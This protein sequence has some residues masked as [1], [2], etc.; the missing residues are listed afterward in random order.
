MANT[1]SD[2]SLTISQLC[3]AAG[4]TPRTVHYYVQQG[5]LPPASVQGRHGTYDSRHLDRLRAI[6]KLQSE[7]LPLAVIRERLQDG[8]LRDDQSADS[9][10]GTA[11][12]EPM[13]RTQWERLA[14]H[15]DIEIH[16]RRPL[17][18][19]QNERLAK[20]LEAARAIFG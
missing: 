2:V 5:L 4:V 15:P 10:A 8:A 20:L 19:V 13:S 11:Q 14:V 16:V 9:D 3:Q 6:R 1:N 7:H 17:S 12:T 18:R